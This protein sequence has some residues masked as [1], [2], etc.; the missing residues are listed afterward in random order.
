MTAVL[1][2][3]RED[4]ANYAFPAAD[5]KLIARLQAERQWWGLKRET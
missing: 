2:T 4:L 5:A 3:F 1:A